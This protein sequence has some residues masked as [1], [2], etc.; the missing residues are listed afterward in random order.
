MNMNQ[1]EMIIFSLKRCLLEYSL[2]SCDEY[3]VDSLYSWIN[4][5][6]TK[7]N[8]NI[9]FKILIFLN[10]KTKTIGLASCKRIKF[11]SYNISSIRF[12]LFNMYY[13]VKYKK[14]IRFD[15]IINFLVEFDRVFKNI[16]PNNLLLRLLSSIKALVI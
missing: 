12:E 16:I 6:P 5:L 3:I 13:M 10:K 2:K 11:S 9:F 7:Y 8:Y 14:F 15:S 4:F 1:T